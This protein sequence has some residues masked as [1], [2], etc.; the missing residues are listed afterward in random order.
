MGV[1]TPEDA[2][3][4]VA[5]DADLLRHDA[6]VTGRSGEAHDR[7][8]LDPAEKGCMGLVDILESMTDGFMHLDRDWRITYVN[9]AGETNLGT[10]RESLLG[11]THWEA[12]PDAVGT[13]FERDLRRAMT[14]RV[15]IRREAFSEHHPRCYEI[16]IHPLLDGGLA[17]YGRDITERKR[18]D[19]HLRTSEERL[20]N[21]FE[22]GL[23][24]LA[25]TSPSKRCVEVNDKLCQMLGYSREEL[26]RMNWVELTHP[27]DLP[28]DLALFRRVL[29]DELDAYTLDKRWLRKDGQV[30]DTTISVKCARLVDR[31]VDYF[32]AM[33]EDVT[34]RKRA[35]AALLESQR[36]LAARMAS[37]VRL[38]EV[39]TRL[40]G[41]DDSTTLL[42]EIIDAAIDITAA[43]MGN[44]QFRDRES[45]TLRI[46]ASR[47]FE[48]SVLDFFNALQERPDPCLASGARLVI[49]D[50]AT[51]A[52]LSDS[53]LRDVLLAAGVRAMQCTPLVSRTGQLLGLL[54]THYR[55]PQYPADRDLRVLDMLARQASD[56]FER[57]RAEEALRDSEQRFRRTFECNM[58]PMG[59]WTRDGGIVEAN[60]ALLDM[61]GYTRE[62]LTHGRVNWMKVTPPEQLYLDERSLAEI[63]EKGVGAPFEK[64]YIHKDGHRVPILIGGAAFTG[65]ANQGVFFAI[66]LSERKRAEEER[67][68][69][70]A[71]ERDARSAAE[72]ANRLKDEFLATL[73]HELRTPINTVLMWIQLMAQG[74]LDETG[75]KKA[76]EVMERGVRAQVRLIDDLLD[77]SRV[78]SGKLRME[79]EQLDLATPI[80]AA[81]E[82]VLPAASAK[83]IALERFMAEESAW[84][85]GDSTRLQQVFWNL[86][87]NAVKFTPEGGE[88]E[89]RMDRASGGW[90]VLVKDSGPGIDPE[91]SQHLFERFRQAD[92]SAA[93]RFGG[94]GLGLAI[95][96]QLVELHGGSVRAESEGEGR[97]STFVVWLPAAHGAEESHGRESSAVLSEEMNLSG[98][99]ILFVDD[100][101]D[102]QTV[103]A[104]ILGECKA[105]TETASSADEALERMSAARPHLLISDIGMPGKDGYQ[106]IREVRRSSEHKSVQAIALTAYARAEDRVRVLSAGYDEY[107]PKPV[108]ARE[109]LSAVASLLGPRAVL[110]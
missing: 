48:R 62:D 86:L 80:Q 105:V 61:L 24:G 104:R 84:V 26:L 87:N 85:R 78:T 70:L 1:W 45:G 106:L 94:L 10:A 89:V 79:V 53:S 55:A 4:A 47:G 49:D 19:E 18:A 37:M 74:S 101:R 73:S 109:L 107:V 76:L 98:T 14:E 2:W 69:L 3:Y 9:Q 96:K 93:R 5:M 68:A 100:D 40:V 88:I 6:R 43:D 57:T 35:E 44:L 91:F 102:T 36:N 54:C 67:K 8:K 34:Q 51:S 65:T 81:I 52:L 33:I 30:V 71:S 99:R 20:R 77:L 82:T 75:K 90:A 17:L 110:R 41:A 42:Q 31:S 39:S 63:E 95:V 97:G 28:A 60:D 21:Y 25:I 103:V 83:G 72:Q 29:A 32:V 46:F 108:N 58:V 92:S 12:F 13:D 38:Q 56:W 15:S 22:L 59:V 50:V 27:D 11:R 64:E 7:R 16:D 23:V 66:D